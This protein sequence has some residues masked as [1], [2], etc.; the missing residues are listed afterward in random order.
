M[1]QRPVARVAGLC[2]LWYAM[3]L[4]MS[5]HYTNLLLS[6]GAASV[7]GVALLVTRMLLPDREGA[8]F[9][10][11]PGLLFYLPW[12]VVEVFKSN[13]AVARVILS[14]RLPIRPRVVDF[15]GHQKTDLGRF[16]YA[17]SI[18]LTPG[19]ITVR[20][21]AEGFR[22]HALTREALDGTEEGEMDRRVCR[23][24]GAS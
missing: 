7:V 22:I 2:L 24:E 6:L 21:D 4:L 19:T 8:P 3:W 13:L 23:L 15:Q 16:I 5:G 18:T 12:L 14:P 1:T 11:V 20:L 9:H 10:I 17:N